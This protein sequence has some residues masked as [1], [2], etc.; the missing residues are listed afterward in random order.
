[1]PVV[2][3]KA[4]SWFTVSCICFFSLDLLK[5][6]VYRKRRQN[7]LVYDHFILEKIIKGFTIRLNTIKVNEIVN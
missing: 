5:W 4:F 6:L 2:V 3:H 7:Q 1:M